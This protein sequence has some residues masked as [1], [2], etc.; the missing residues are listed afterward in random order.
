MSK[1]KEEFN[2]MDLISDGD[3]AECKAVAEAWRQSEAEEEWH[4]KN[5]PN[6]EQWKKERHDVLMADIAAHIVTKEELAARKAAERERV[7]K[8]MESVDW[9]AEINAMFGFEDD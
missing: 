1:N 9:D 4:R 5:D 6:Y 2:L 8:H 3:R 7:K